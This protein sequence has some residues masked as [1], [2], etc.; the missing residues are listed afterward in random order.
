MAYN[1]GSRFAG[2]GALENVFHRRHST[3]AYR[4]KS[5]RKVC[6]PAQFYLLILGIS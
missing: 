6:S 5:S 3:D 1:R 2:L 4:K